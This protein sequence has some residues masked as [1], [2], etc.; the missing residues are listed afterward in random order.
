[1]GFLSLFLKK[2]EMQFHCVLLRIIPSRI[3][4]T[5]QEREGTNIIKYKTH[6]VNSKESMYAYLQTGKAEIMFQNW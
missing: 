2:G 6:L 1:M 5:V 3:K 4:V